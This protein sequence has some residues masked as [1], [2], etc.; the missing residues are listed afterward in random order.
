LGYAAWATIA[1]A[2]ATL[3]AAATVAVMSRRAP[4]AP[5]DVIRFDL[6][7]PPGTIRF[8]HSMPVRG[9]GIPAPHFAVSPDGSTLAFTAVSAE[10]PSVHLWVRS[11]SSIEARRLPG[12][13][14]ASFPFWSPDNRQIAFF[15]DSSLKTIRLDGESPAIVGSVEGGEG[16]SWGPDGTILFAQRGSENGIFRIPASGGTPITVIKTTDSNVRQVWPC[17]VADGQS[18]IYYTYAASPVTEG[19]VRWHSFATNADAEV[20]KANARAIYAG[21]YLLFVRDG[22][23]LA[24]PLDV[25]RGVLGGEA[26]IVQD[27]VAFNAVQ[28]RAA[29]HASNTGVLAFRAAAAIELGQLVWWSRAG[30]RLSTSETPEFLARVNLAPNGL[31]AL[32]QINTGPAFGGGVSDLW[33]HDIDRGVRERF[34]SE[35][36]AEHSPVWSRDGSMVAYGAVSNRLTPAS[37]SA[38]WI[39]A[40]GGAEPARQV[41]G[42]VGA[43]SD[44]APDGKGIVAT[45]IDSA[46]GGT[47]VVVFPID[48]GPEKMLLGGPFAQRDAK[49]SPDGRWVAYLSDENGGQFDVFLQSFPLTNRKTRVSAPS[50]INPVWN[51]NSRELLYS[52]LGDI[53]AVDV[54]ADGTVSTPRLILRDAAQSNA[55]RGLADNFAISADG[56]RL[57]TITPTATATTAPLTILVNWPTLIEQR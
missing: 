38:I 23:L 51:G 57:L 29:F 37:E 33:M 19:T 16:G 52:S 54:R 22:R 32:L 9:P 3:T 24:Q 55:A 35:P 42:A 53:Y 8:G 46:R 1:L 34:T 39:K 13:E 11:L 44:W 41:R 17:W 56:Q 47:D 21:G 30:A 14:D 18:F 6:E 27:A 4:T 49:F 12:T 48:G 45:R 40:A 5:A 26:R 2:L 28:G 31:R 36:G 50:G 10:Q 20:T 7:L 25:Q 43:P 15:A